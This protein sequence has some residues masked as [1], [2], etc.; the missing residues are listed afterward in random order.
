MRAV[1]TISIGDEFSRIAAM[2]HPL[3]EAYARRI[4]AD[5]ISLHGD[6]AK[7]VL[8]KFRLFE[9][10]GLYERVVYLDSDVIVKPDCPNL[11]ELVPFDNFGAWLT[12][13]HGAGFDPLIARIQKH[14]PDLGWRKTYF[15]GGVLVVSQQHRDA[16]VKTI[17][18]EDEMYDRTLLNYRVQKLGYEIFDIGYKFNHTAAASRV[19]DRFASN[20]LHYAGVGGARVDM[21]RSD[22]RHLGLLPS[23]C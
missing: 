13:R 5:F 12:S 18:Y 8:E 17:E 9:F 7:P 2:T 15:N 11:F 10:L 22:L 19:A 20:I 6:A 16:F 3:M 14:L 23:G 21:I 4:G 1:I